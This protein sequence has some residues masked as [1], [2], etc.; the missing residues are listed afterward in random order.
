[1]GNLLLNYS[2][3]NEKDIITPTAVA[4]Y[5]L[6]FLLEVFDSV[7]KARKVFKYVKSHAA[8]TAYQPYVISASGTVGSEII[9]AAPATLAAPGLLVCIPQVVIASGYYGFVLIE[10]EGKVL[11]TAQ[12]YAAG[13]FLRL[14]NAGTA[15]LVEGTSGSTVQ[16]VSSSAICKETGTTAVARKVYLLGDKAILAAT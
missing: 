13:D 16:L 3:V 5:P 11:M 1:M 15:L 12:T 4:K 6:G 7:S 8:L 2:Q 14:I 9:T 10:G